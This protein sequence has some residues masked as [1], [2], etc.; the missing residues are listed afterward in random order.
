VT[1]PSPANLRA[2]VRRNTEL[3]AVPDLP[4]VELHTAADVTIV[5]HLAAA[6]LGQF[7]PPLP[8]WA[9]AW[10]GGLALARYLTEHPELV[11]GRRV[12]DL[13]SGSGLCGIVAARLGAASVHAFDVDPLSGAAVDLNARAN[14]VR[15]AF[16]L[17]DPLDEPAPDCDV[18]L[19][20][21]VCYEE[22]MASRTIDWLRAAAAD[23]VL[24]LLGDPGRNY[25]PRDL[26]RLATYRIHTTRELEESEV[27]ESAVYTIP[28]AR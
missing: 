27:K 23:G 12:V 21:D 4:G 28:G 2:F 1:R 6:E 11:E 16:S 22:T 7:D 25:L 10:A 8:F 20:G 24:I 3:Q 17:A 14:D 18:V 19:A 26:T 9:F 15:V 13:A 5:W